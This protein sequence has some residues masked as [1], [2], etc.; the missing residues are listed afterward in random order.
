MRRGTYVDTL[1][2]VNGCDSVVTLNLTV[3]DILRTD[4]TDS[5]CAGESLDFNGQIASTTGIY[6]HTMIS[7]IGCDSVITLDLTVLPVNTETVFDTICEGELYDF[8][9]SLLDVTGSYI[10]T[11]VGSNGCDSIVT[12]ELTVNPI[13]TFTFD[14]EVCEGTPYTFG[15]LNLD[16]TG[17]Y[18]DTLTNALGCDSIVTLNL[19]VHPVYDTLITE[20]ICEGTQFDFNGTLLDVS[21]TYVDTL[22]SVNG[23]DSVVTLNLTV[24]DILRTDLTDSICAGESLDFNGQIAST[25]GIY[26]HTMISSIGCDSVITLDLTVLPV[27]TEE[28]DIEICDGQTF[29]FNGSSI[30]VAGTYIDTVVGSNGCD[31]IVTLNLIVNPVENT[32]LDVEICDGEQYDFGGELLSETGVYIH[33]LTTQFGCDSIVTLNLQV[34]PTYS[35]D[36]SVTICEGKS[37]DFNG[38]VITMAGTYIDTLTTITGCDSIQILT[39]D[40]LPILRTD[41]QIEICEDETYDFNGKSLS[42]TGIYI[43]TLQSSI[44]C[45]SVVTLD[46]VVNII[47]YGSENVE[48][49]DDAT[50]DFHGQELST[51]GTY[52]DTLTNATGCDSIVTLELIV[53]QTYNTV[54]EYSICDGDSVEI[55]GKVYKT[56]GAFVDSLQSQYGCDSIL[57]ISIAVREI[58]YSEINASICNDITYD[59]NG[60]ILDSAGIYID[61]LIS[62]IGCD[63]IITLDLEVLPVKRHSFVKQV[64]LNQTYSFI[65]ATLTATGIYVD[66]ISAANGCDSIVTVDFRVVD[67]IEV[68]IRDTIC[69]NEV[70]VYNDKIYDTAGDYTDTLTAEGGCDSIMHIN[71]YVAPVERTSISETICEGETYDFLGA[72]IVDEGIYYDTLSTIFGCDSIIELTLT[73]IPTL[74]TDITPSIC[75]GDSFSIGDTVFTLSGQYDVTLTAATTGCDSVVHIELTVIATRRHTDTIQICETDF[76][77]FNGVQYDSTGIYID[78]LISSVGCDSIDILELYVHPLPFTTIMYNLCSGEEVEIGGDVFTTDTTFTLIYGGIYGCDSTVT[79]EVTFLP[80]VTLSASSVQI[81]EGEEIELQLEVTGT[82]EPIVTW[83]PAEG[84]SCTDCLNPVASP[85]ETTVYTVT[86]IGCGGVVVEIEV[87]VEI[88]PLPGLTVTEDQTIDLGQTVTVQGTNNVPTIPINWYDGDSGDPLCSDCPNLVQQPKKAGVYHF[89]ASAVNSLGCGEEDTVTITV[90]DPCELEKIE[91]ANAFTPNNDG[92]NDYF[93]IRNNGI[94]SIALVQIFNRWGEIVFETQDINLKWDGNFRGEPVNP[95]VY[96]YIIRETV[97]IRKHSN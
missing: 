68:D 40:V 60:N 96:M 14:D 31:S 2:S 46:L 83:S 41:L 33:T 4:L 15:S 5:I 69:E 24:L 32:I 17:T 3:L 26:T 45:D 44:G 38:L 74:H 80:D 37:Y 30:G 52:V 22:N 79:Y 18:I 28:I 63:S 81:C 85:A 65:G 20:Q 71:I 55:A 82:E 13:V 49:C 87:T 91:A 64:C 84:L 7:S 23:C 75:E 34:N 94:S 56:A 54:L 51:S 16:S 53:H 8:N 92:F 36:L 12:L 95:G 10:D 6:T 11:V 66:T 25:T 1:N 86:T 9:G 61:T 97:S 19:T 57:G 93:E 39:V 29:D 47:T 73:V 90:I 35:E 43:D 76:Y 70:A 62:S 59:F 72:P 42:T 78:T 50:Y 77:T 48:I 89:V 88:I 21:G 58:R 27:N 67:V